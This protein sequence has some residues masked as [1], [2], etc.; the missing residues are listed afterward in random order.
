MA[1]AKYEFAEAIRVKPGYARAHVALGLVQLASGERQ[2]A[3]EQFEEA[4]RQ[5]PEDK[6]AQ[7]YLRMAKNP[8][9]SDTG[10][11]GAPDSADAPADD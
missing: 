9:I 11:P 10:R 4:L 1:A 8:P 2:K 7:M 5:S 6:S 3:I